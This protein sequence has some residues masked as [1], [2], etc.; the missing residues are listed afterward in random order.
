METTIKA[1]R[2]THTTLKDL[3]QKYGYDKTDADIWN[4]MGITSMTAQDDQGHPFTLKDVQA[5]IDF[6]NS[7]GIPFL[8]MWSINRD[9]NDNSW[10]HPGT[11]EGITVKHL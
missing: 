1:L 7:V 3:Y 11:Q 2:S 5:T 9:S 10:V 6:A 4:L 8:S